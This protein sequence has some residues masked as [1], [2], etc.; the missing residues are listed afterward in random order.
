MLSLTTGVDSVWTRKG[1]H[2]TT[3]LL[4]VAHSRNRSTKP[5]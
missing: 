4:H 5:N 1:T 3:L 2:E